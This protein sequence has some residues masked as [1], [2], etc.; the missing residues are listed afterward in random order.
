MCGAGACLAPLFLLSARVTLGPTA[1][2]HSALCAGGQIG[3][4]TLSAQRGRD[5]QEPFAELG[6]KDGPAAGS[7]AP[8]AVSGR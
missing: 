2:L 3:Q 8:G 4:H 5:G 7:Q 1:H 6:L